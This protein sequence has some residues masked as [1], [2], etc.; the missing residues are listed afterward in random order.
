MAAPP[1]S[2]CAGSALVIAVLTLTLSISAYTPGANA[3]SGGSVMADG[4]APFFGAFACP[5]SIPFGSRVT[6]I[7][8]AAERARKLR[9]PT[10]GVCADRF[11]RQYSSGRLDVC[12]PDGYAGYSDA[13]RLRWARAWGRM[14]GEVV[15]DTS[16][17]GG[18]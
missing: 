2:R 17:A 14:R 4:R 11:A 13:A 5:H 16:T 6:L 1:R 8:R 18:Q 12:I 10:T 7:G 15:I 3:I 9:L